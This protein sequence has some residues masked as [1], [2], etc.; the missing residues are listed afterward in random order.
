MNIKK[1]LEELNVRTQEIF[2]ETIQ[3]S[4]QFGKAHNIAVNI[5]E[6][7][8]SVMDVDERSMLSSVSSQ[9]E[10]SVLN[11][12]LGLYRQSFFSLRLA[13]EM[14]LGA[15]HFSINKLEYQ[16]WTKGEADIKWARLTNE[17]DGILSKRFANAFFPELNSFICTQ[18]KKAVAVYRTLS[19]YVHGNKETWNHDGVKLR[20][21][22]SLV[23]MFFQKYHD[24]GEV[25]LFLLSCRYLKSIS[26]FDLDSVDFLKEDLNHI[27]PIRTLF[28]N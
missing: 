13:L 19:E 28:I 20:Y 1:H 26:N 21:N 22:P 23:D 24:I 6:F 9:L 17:D 15:I 4:I 7:S 16:E 10:Y 25:V 11:L 2:S 18:R 14:G 5:Y 8:E 12:A 3:N 27:G